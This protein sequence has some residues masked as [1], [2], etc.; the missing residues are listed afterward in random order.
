[1]AEDERY[2]QLSS[3]FGA[4][5]DWGKQYL[6]AVL[7]AL[8]FAQNVMPAQVSQEGNCPEESALL[9][10]RKQSIHAGN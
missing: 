5:S 3:R 1:M 10:E 8:E 2:E 6:L 4:L 7:K 9:T